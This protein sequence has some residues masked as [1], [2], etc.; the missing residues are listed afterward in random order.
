M[1]INQED[2]FRWGCG[3]SYPNW[4]VGVALAWGAKRDWPKPE[5]PG[6]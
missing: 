5:E 3:W 1:A 2:R 4:R 6:S